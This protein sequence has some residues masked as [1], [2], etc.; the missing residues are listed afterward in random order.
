MLSSSV[1]TALT[2]SGLP[3][4]SPVSIQLVK[5]YNW[6]GYPKTTSSATSS[7]LSGLNL[8]DNEIIYGKDW[9]D[10]YYKGVWTSATEN[11]QMEAGKGYLLNVSAAQTL[12]F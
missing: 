12:N 4:S 6:I 11:P 5:G 1:N 7:V 10:T 9:L 2:V 3:P 8:S